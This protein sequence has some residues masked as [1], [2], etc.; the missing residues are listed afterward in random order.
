MPYHR[1]EG[2]NPINMKVGNWT[3]VLLCCSKLML[4]RMA[5]VL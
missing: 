5:I 3:V 4:Q 1:A 2:M